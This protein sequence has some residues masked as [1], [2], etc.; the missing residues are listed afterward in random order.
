MSASEEIIKRVRARAFNN[1]NRYSCCSQAVL[2]ALQ[3]EFK[4]GNSQSLKSA[5]ALDGGVACLGETCGAVIGALM[6]LGLVIG[7]EKMEDTL[8]YDNTGNASRELIERFKVELQKHFEFKEKLESTLC[9]DIQ[10]K[11]LGRSFN[12]LDE[13]ENQAF[14]NVG[15]HTERGCL[16]VCAIAAEAHLR[17]ARCLPTR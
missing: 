6:A 17:G 7:R 14:L 4:I 8:A 16:T 10:K 1:D 13:K 15:A 11:I 12:F 9:R 3:E 5:T 2:E